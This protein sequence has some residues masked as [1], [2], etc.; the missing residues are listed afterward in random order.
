[1]Y[2]IV[3]GAATAVPPPAAPR[4]PRRPPRPVLL[5]PE[6]RRDARDEVLR[7]VGDEALGFM[8]FYGELGVAVLRKCSPE[9]AGALVR[10]HESGDLDRLGNPEAV[11]SAVLGGGTLAAEWLAGH[12]AELEDPDAMRCW[13]REPMEYVYALKDLGLE[14]SRLRARREAAAVNRGSGG[15]GLTVLAA[16]VLAVVACL[17][18]RKWRAA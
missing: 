1:M 17:A 18:Y 4:P 11:L 9:S 3:L 13:V 7:E 16:L 6:A 12:H 15:N 5:D 14:A 10:L 2:P 8:Q